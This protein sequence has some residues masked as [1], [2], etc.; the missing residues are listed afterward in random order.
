[1][2]YEWWFLLISST[3]FFV[4]HGKIPQA[5]VKG[6]HYRSSLLAGNGNFP[7]EPGPSRFAYNGCRGQLGGAIDSSFRV[8]AGFVMGG[9]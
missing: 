8:A 3:P 7:P 1:M 4:V 9:D 2:R 5:S 6:Q